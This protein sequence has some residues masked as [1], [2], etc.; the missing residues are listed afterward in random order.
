[1]IY[2][3][4]YFSVSKPFYGFYNYKELFQISGQGE[5]I[6]NG[7]YKVILE[8]AFEKPNDYLPYSNQFERSLLG[9]KAI[10]ITHCV[11]YH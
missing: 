7:N 6:S 5:K 11:D 8:L 9:K 1:L 4:L 2:E 10:E 3:Q